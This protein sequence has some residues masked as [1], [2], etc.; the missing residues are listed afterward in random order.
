MKKEVVPK[1]EGKSFLNTSMLIG[2]LPSFN[3]YGFTGNAN[4][5]FYCQPFGS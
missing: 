5:L 1:S 3:I 4:V 2:M